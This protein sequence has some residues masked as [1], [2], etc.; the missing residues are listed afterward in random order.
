MRNAVY[1]HPCTPAFH[2]ELELTTTSTADG[3]TI[4]TDRVADDSWASTAIFQV[5]PPI[6]PTLFS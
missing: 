2:R 3:S 1:P 5:P 4:A 6:S